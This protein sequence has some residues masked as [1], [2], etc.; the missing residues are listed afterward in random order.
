MA[1]LSELL[2]ELDG[3]TSPVEK[4]AA[5]TT[6]KEFGNS[7]INKML[8]D[9]GLVNEKDLAVEK[10]ASS[11][12][13]GKPMSSLYDAVMEKWAEADGKTS[14]GAV[15]TETT[16]TTETVENDIEKIAS[17]DQVQQVVD[18]LGARAGE[19]WNEIF[20]EEMQKIASEMG[21]APDNSM[22]DKGAAT[23]M[24]GETGDPRVETN[25]PADSA[26]HVDTAP[27][28]Y[29]LDEGQK[30]LVGMCMKKKIMVKS[31][32]GRK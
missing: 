4:T 32:E 11:T 13:G 12:E 18:V 21:I 9:S 3:P 30:A 31:L 23:G 5:D 8:V 17:S 19:Y 14:E 7:E 20:N 15:T 28:Y 10:V 22:K 26:K 27:K 24:F 6:V 16:E 29:D 2:K 1:T 25:R